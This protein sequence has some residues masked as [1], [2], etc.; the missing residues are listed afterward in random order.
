[1]DTVWTWAHRP[2]D[3]PQQQ[4]ATARLRP[5]DPTC[6]MVVTACPSHSV[7]QVCC[8]ASL[9]FSSCAYRVHLAVPPPPHPAGSA[10]RD[11]RLSCAPPP[12]LIHFSLSV[13][14]HTTSLSLH[15]L[16]LAC[17]SLPD[18]HLRAPWRERDRI[19]VRSH[20]Q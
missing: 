4:I 1:M 3:S 10:R 14:A 11:C 12:S 6:T 20:R 19:Q 5:S 9:H 8:C 13:T 2:S 18:V 17:L 16:F 15:S 7:S